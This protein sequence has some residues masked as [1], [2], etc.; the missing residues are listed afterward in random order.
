[1]DLAFFPNVVLASI[2]V[3]IRISA[4][5][6]ST[7]LTLSSVNFVFLLNPAN[8]LFISSIVLSVLKFQIEKII[9]M[10]LLRIFIVYSFHVCSIWP[11]VTQLYYLFYTLWLKNSD[12]WHFSQIVA[13]LENWSPFSRSFY[14]KQIWYR[15]CIFWMATLFVNCRFC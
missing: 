7:S 13:S 10:S 9:S 14:V 2:V 15:F 6:S 1:M 3:V 8:E 12:I 4:N 5:L 11:H